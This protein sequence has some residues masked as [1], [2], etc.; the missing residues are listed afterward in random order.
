[1][2]M[3][4][5]LGAISTKWPKDFVGHVSLRWYLETHISKKMPTILSNNRKVGIIS[6]R[7]I[8]CHNIRITNLNLKSLNYS[9]HISVWGNQWAL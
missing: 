5:L 2:Y 8:K 7:Q 3:E 1:M 4:K 6:E 9:I